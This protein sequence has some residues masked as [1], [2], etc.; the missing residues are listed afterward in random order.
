MNL[1]RDVVII[2]GGPAGLSAALTLGLARRNVLVL[3]N[4][5]LRSAA[6][7]A[8]H[9]L[10]S[11]DGA[12]P[13]DILAAAREQ[14]GAYRSVEV[15]RDAAVNVETQDGLPVVE[16]MSG[17]KY[18]CRKLIL[19]AGTADV[20]PPWPGLAE[21]WGKSIFVC[22]YCHA[23]EYRDRPLAVIGGEAGVSRTVAVLRSWSNDIV[24]LTNGSSQ[25]AHE[26]RFL[27]DRSNI[28]VYDQAIASFE[29][30]AGQLEGVRFQ[31]GSFLPRQAIHYRPAVT[32][33]LIPKSLGLIQDGQFRVHSQTAQTSNPNVYVA[34]DMAGL[35]RPAALPAAVYGGS[36]AGRSVNQALANEDLME[37][38]S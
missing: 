7:A 12:A 25:L 8:S 5:M 16:T 11:R 22:P 24:L 21:C 27:L 15:V 23:W 35:F 3:D 20:L 38:S 31:E 37:F 28:R 33:N 4:G 30:S 36:F 2:G 10:L 17:Q 9:G 13:G 6:A 1:R 26:E 14:L 19:A 18:R 29:H 34:G 32:Q